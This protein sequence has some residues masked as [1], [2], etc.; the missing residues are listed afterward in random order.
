MQDYFRLHFV[1]VILIQEFFNEELVHL[2][3]DLTV[4]QIHDLIFVGL[5]FTF[6]QI[7]CL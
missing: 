1:F 6:F 4:E 2:L 3:P 5:T 7:H